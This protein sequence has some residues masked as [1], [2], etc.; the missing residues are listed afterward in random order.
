[1]GKGNTNMKSGMNLFINELSIVFSK[2]VE[3]IPFNDV[4]Y[5]F[6]QMGSG[7]TS[8]ARL[9]NYCLG[10]SIHLSPALQ[11]EFV[12]AT[13]TLTIK[14]KQ[15]IVQR[16]RGS[17][18]VTTTWEIDSGEFYT[19]QLPARQPN[20]IVLPGTNVEQLSDLLFYLSDISP[21]KVR[22]S[23]IKEDSELQRLSFRDLFWYC[24]ID[25]DNIDSSFFN[26]DDDADVF[27]R[28]KSRDVM[29]FLLGFHQEKVA[30]LEAKL[31]NI[32]IQTL[33]LNTAATSLK[34]VIKEANIGTEN[35]INYELN[36]L[37]SKFEHNSAIINQEPEKNES[38]PHGAD[39]LKERA[40][41]LGNEIQALEDAII[42]VSKRVD[43]D[44]RHRNEILILNVKVDRTA[45]ARAVLGGVEFCSCPRCAQVLPVRETLH[46]IVCGQDEPIIGTGNMNSQLIKEDAKSRIF[47]L[48]EIVNL[49]EEQKEIM[50]Q[51]LTELVALKSEVDKEISR[52]L[53]RYDS[54][55]LSTILAFEKENSQIAEK[56]KNLNHLKAIPEK[57]NELLDRAA[58]SSAEEIRLRAELKA[59]RVNAERDL[60]NLDRLKALFLDCLIRCQLPGI[61]PDSLVHIKVSDFLPFIS[62]PTMGDVA[63]TS[64][65][66]LSSG[67]KKTLFK[68]CFAIAIHRLAT[69]IGALMPSILI[70]D[71]PMKNISERENKTQFEN[72]HNLIYELVSNELVGTQIILIDK[73][74]FD[75]SKQI[76]INMSIRHM[77]LDEDQF[78]PLIPY[79]RE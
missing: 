75:P 25:Q 49:Q 21:P 34:A 42:E 2:T 38:F 54:A 76:F 18:Q 19:L 65:S 56:I 22:R 53:A 68:A 31:Q 52:Q 28:L 27:K 43:Q 59:E 9:I 39:I 16:Q 48:N 58:V 78:P 24:Y 30:E 29:R 45:A 71:S 55:Y 12:S 40:R 6:G 70:I 64:F 61:N 57:V 33:Q 8:I 51:R 62:N 74:H 66:N 67:G 3:N 72:F 35:E 13:L 69:E 50:Q 47:E 63:V 73:E 41:S 44:T 17:D 32:H 26:L 7:K 46:C 60:T 79:Y 14:E 4:T 5:F 1:M 36:E 15:V 77:K 37:N 20:G 23:K 10:G 11:S